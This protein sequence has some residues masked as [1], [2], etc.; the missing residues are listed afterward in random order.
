MGVPF[1]LGTRVDSRRAVA[2]VAV[3]V[4]IGLPPPPPG[5]CSVS[6]SANVRVQLG[7]TSKKTDP[8]H[9]HMLTT[10]LFVANIYAPSTGNKDVKT[11]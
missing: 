1:S 5:V 10:K 8:N 3:A 11:G 9:V 2:V 7:S 4:A 6:P